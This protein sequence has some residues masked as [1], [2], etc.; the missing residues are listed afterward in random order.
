MKKIFGIALTIVLSAVLFAGCGGGGDKTTTSATPTTSAVITTTKA[1]TSAAPTTTSSPTTAVSTPTTTTSAAPTTSSVPTTSAAPS[2]TSDSDILADIFS[3]SAAIN[4]MYCEVNISSTD[5]E[6]EPYTIKEWVK[7]DK[8]KME[9]TVDGETVIIIFNGQDM[10][11]YYPSENMAMKYPSETG[12]DTYSSALD[13]TESMG[14]YDPVL[15]GSETVDGKDCYVF[16]YSAEGYS[17]KMWVCKLG[18]VPIKIT[19]TDSSG[20]MTMLYTNYKFDKI[21]DSEFELPAG[22]EVIDMSDMTSYP[23][24]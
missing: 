24:M 20:T 15:V 13:D 4:N 11:M 14:D 2:T 8:M 3:K 6:F 21:P 1:T 16:E 12:E 7:Q 23:G 22:V 5:P 10:Y 17:T 18:G 9:M 19:S